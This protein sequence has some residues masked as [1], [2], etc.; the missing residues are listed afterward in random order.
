MQDGVEE[1]WVFEVGAVAGLFV[2]DGLDAGGERLV[3]FDR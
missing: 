1:E 3:P 2:G